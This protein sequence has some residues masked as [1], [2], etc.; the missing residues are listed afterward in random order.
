MA[1]AQKTRE[2]VVGTKGMYTYELAREAVRLNFPVRV[3]A[4]ALKVS[5]QTIYNW[6]KGAS[7]ATV[8]YKEPID[9]LTELL[10]T[11]PDLTTA[12]RKVKRKFNV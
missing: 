7:S 12:R 9:A 4:Q 8:V 2:A 3:I 6:F 1:Y 11:S 10:A 5:R